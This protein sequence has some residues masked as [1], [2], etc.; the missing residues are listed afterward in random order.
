MFFSPTAFGSNGLRQTMSLP[1]LAAALLLS[2]TGGDA[3]QSPNF[4]RPVF[5]C[6]GELSGESGFVASEGFPALYPT[7]KKCKWTITVAEGNVVVLSFRHLDMESDPVCRYDR[8]DV[9]NGDGSGAER[10]GSFCGTFRPGSVISTGNTM[11][12]E[13]VSDEDNVGKGFLAIYTAGLTQD[14]ENS[15]CGGR[16]DKPQGS[17]QTPNWP[18]KNYPTGISCAWHITGRAGQVIELTFEK[19]DVEGDNYCRYDYVA[20][21]N[22]GRSDE[23]QRAG[24]F[25]G[26]TPPDPVVS[27][28]NEML[29]QFVSDLSV[30]AG[31]FIARYDMRP[32][33]SGGTGS[34][35]RP[36]PPVH[37]TRPPRTPS[38]P[39]T[40]PNTKPNRKGPPVPAIC[41]TKCR[42]KGNLQNNFCQ[43]EFVVSGTVSAVTPSGH[44]V[45]VSLT[46]IKAYKTGRLRVESDEQGERVT[47]AVVCRRCPILKQ[48]LKYTL[49]GAVDSQGRGKILPNTFFLIYKPQQQQLLTRLQSRRC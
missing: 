6:G 27:V 47:I 18:Q 31:G 2:A 12:L 30:T 25:C 5:L 7:N 43:S 29:V 19:F 22:G 44:S 48:G 39:N 35:P 4:T 20:V 24:K 26:D 21:F 32:T 40:K 36:R 46:L 8:L 11:T 17:I 42:R 13:M 23:A 15:L 1:F 9:F 28:G 41:R 49:M 16:L 34:K 33:R 37:P 38:K 3:Q 14:R 10:L 45:M